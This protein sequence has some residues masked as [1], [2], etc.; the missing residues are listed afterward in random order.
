MKVVHSQFYIYK[1]SWECSKLVD[2]FP[3]WV[4]DNILTIPI[5]QFDY[6]DVLVWRFTVDGVYSGKSSYQLALNKEEN[7]AKGSSEGCGDGWKI[8]SS[9][10]IPHC[11]YLLWRICII[12]LQV[13]TR[14]KGYWGW[15]YL[16][17]V[18]R[19]WR[20]C[21]SCSTPLAQ[22]LNLSGMHLLFVLE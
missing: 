15:Y 16:L 1:R 8:W 11:K 14:E 3:T 18:W 20:N 13:C 4:I 21:G 5:K 10:A 22:K 19:V 2:F 7:A 17:H 6:H 12:A 9:N